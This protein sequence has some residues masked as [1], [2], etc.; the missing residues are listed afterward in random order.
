MRVCCSALKRLKKCDC[1][2]YF[3]SVLFAKLFSSFFYGFR[4]PFVFFIFAKSERET[5]RVREKEQCVYLWKVHGKILH[6]WKTSRKKIGLTKQN[7]Q[8]SLTQIF[9]ILDFDFSSFCVDFHLLDIVA[10]IQSEKE[11][12]SLRPTSHLRQTEFLRYLRALTDLIP[13]CKPA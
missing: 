5:E 12:S 10:K 8:I 13:G 2:Y 7:Y 3:T 6:I 9:I 4:I 11:I 1:F